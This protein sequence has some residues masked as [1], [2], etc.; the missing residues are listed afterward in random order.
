MTTKEL[1]KFFEEHLV[2]SKIYSLKGNHKNKIC[3]EKRE[4]GWQVYFSDEKERIGILSFA[5]ESEACNRM[6]EEIE[7]VMELVYGLKFCNFAVC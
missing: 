3:L 5:A 4:E 7:K 1:K 6:K 2:P